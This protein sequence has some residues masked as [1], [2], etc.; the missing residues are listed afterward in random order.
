MS[1]LIINSNGKALKRR[2]TIITLKKR[3]VG[4]TTMYKALKEYFKGKYDVQV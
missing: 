3:Q 2:I 1:K 4:A